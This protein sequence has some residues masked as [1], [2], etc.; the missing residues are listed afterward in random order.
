ME[1]G[2]GLTGDKVCDCAHHA[3][4][5]AHRAGATFT[6]SASLRLSGG[7]VLPV[8]ARGHL[9]HA[10]LHLGRRREKPNVEVEK[11]YFS[12]LSFV[13]SELLSLKFYVSPV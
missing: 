12:P 8:V 10:G 3:H 5:G 1:Q 4:G 7:Q 2:R 11:M 13:S 6:L 9:L